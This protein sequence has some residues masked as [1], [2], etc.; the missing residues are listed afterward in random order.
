MSGL[1]RATLGWDAPDEIAAPDP[2]HV[3]DEMPDETRKD[4]RR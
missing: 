1:T 2:Q 4:D 3:L